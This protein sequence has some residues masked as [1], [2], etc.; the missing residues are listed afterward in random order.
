MI[1]ECPAFFVKFDMTFHI[2]VALE[3]RWKWTQNEGTI[4]AIA[5][6]SRRHVTCLLSILLNKTG[7]R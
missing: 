3:L 7:Q 2:F 4:A 6:S 1:G 5:P